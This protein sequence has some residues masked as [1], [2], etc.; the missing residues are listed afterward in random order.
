MTPTF[1]WKCS[2]WGCQAY[3]VRDETGM[4]EV[5]TRY[6]AHDRERSISTYDDDGWQRDVLGAIGLLRRSANSGTPI[7]QKTVDAFNAWRMAEHAAHVKRLRDNP[8]R[9]GENAAD[10]VEPPMVV[11]GAR[12]VVGRGWVVNGNG[13]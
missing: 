3:E 13:A 12:Y 4:Y 6:L 7:P 9:Y 2:W 1:R 5:E 10:E 11:R 8:D